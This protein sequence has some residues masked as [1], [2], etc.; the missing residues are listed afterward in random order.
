VLD[1]LDVAA[2]RRWSIDAADALDACRTE[3][4]DLN[5][6]PVPDGDTGTN[7]AI[8]MRAAAEAL[9]AETPA[10][11]TSALQALARGAVLGARGNSGVILAQVLRGLADA[12]QRN[13]GSLAEPALDAAA[14]QRGFR[15]A[16]ERAYEAVSQPVE[17]TILTVLR[18]AADSSAA[19]ALAGG[20][21]IT[22]VTGALSAAREALTHTPEQ[23]PVL[24]RANVVDAGGRG[25]IVVIEALVAVITDAE[26]NQDVAMLPRRSEPTVERSAEIDEPDCEVQYLLEADSASVDALRAV[27]LELGDAVVVAGTGD[28]H[29]NVH[30]H[31]PFPAAGRA[32]EAGIEAGRP[33]RI[34]VTPFVIGLHVS[35]QVHCGHGGDSIL[36]AVG[37]ERGFAELFAEEGVLAYSTEAADEAGADGLIELINSTGARRAVLVTCDS[38]Y[39]AMAERV[40]SHVR[41]SDLDVG[42]VPTHAPVQALSAI[43]VHD[44]DRRLADD[45]VAMTEAATATRWAEVTI[46]DAQ[47]LTSVGTCHPGDYL[48]L[49][50]GEVVIIGASEFEVGTALLDRLLGVGAELVTVIEGAGSEATSAQE[51][52]AYLHTHASYVEVTTLRSERSCMVIGAE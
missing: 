17:G 40:A 49:I 44:N 51:I 48:G 37:L 13:V 50:A 5:V 16:V 21:L 30:V 6:F 45:L 28:G 47:A 25:L 41:D 19:A 22:V 26:P 20:A 42:V 43:A 1:R 14:L 29:W 39:T 2:I 32:V 4:D 38:D 12:E 15:R 33:Y 9:V 7:L 36:I 35:P 27:L 11:P 52:E 3:I 18:A 24:A 31:T 10:T 23:L 8:T 34:T 46:A